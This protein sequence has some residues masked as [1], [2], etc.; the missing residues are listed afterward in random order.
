[1]TTEKQCPLEENPPELAARGRQSVLGGAG[2]SA[3]LAS[4]YIRPCSVIVNANLRAPPNTS[5]P[6]RRRGRRGH[7]IHDFLPGCDAP[8][9]LCPKTVPLVPPPFDLASFD[10]AHR[11]QG[12]ARWRY[13]IALPVCRAEIGIAEDGGAPPPGYAEPP[14]REPGSPSSQLSGRVFPL[15]LRVS[16]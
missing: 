7:H 16:V 15:C 4:S 11:R 14:L 5:S 6:Q 9:N 12:R 8:M 1:M 3:P 10:F 2:I 13:G